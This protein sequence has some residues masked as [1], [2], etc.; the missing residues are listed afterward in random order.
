MFKNTLDKIIAYNENLTVR[1]RLITL[2][3]VGLAVT[4]AL[5][6]LIQLTVLDKILVDQQ[7]K[8]LED[9]A[10][11]VSTFYQYFPTKRGLLSFDSALK[12][13]IQ[14]DVR[15][16]RIDIFDVGHNDVDYVAGAGRVQY[17]WPDNIVAS[18]STKRKSH[19]AKISTEG[20]PA[21]GLLYPVSEEIKDSRIVIGIIGFSR[22][23]AE[24][25]GRA[26]QLFMVSSG[27]LLL[28]ILLFLGLSYGWVIG[29][30]LKL[31]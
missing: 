17:E 3:V 12:D 7:A 1:V 8:R 29:G 9:V 30:P 13:H 31:F 28:M 16:A 2:T 21:L 4:M 27:G 10:E 18:A 6:G 23:N 14:T 24:I 15:L 25:M 22:A 11:T 26:Q 5:W 19:Y 20:G